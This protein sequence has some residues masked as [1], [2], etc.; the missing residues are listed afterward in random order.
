MAQKHG[1]V[2]G[3]SHHNVW[4]CA[5][6]RNSHMY[7]EPGCGMYQF[8]LKMGQA[9]C[10]VEKCNTESKLF[11]RYVLCL[12]LRLNSSPSAS[13]VCLQQ[14][15]SLGEGLGPHHLHSTARQASTPLS[16]FQPLCPAYMDR[17]RRSSPFGVNQALI[18]NI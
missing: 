10:F 2:A 4:P 1:R 15:W 14:G 13:P 17:T 3:K 16:L 18:M 9:P 11:V 6:P 12:V 7:W 5:V 8:G